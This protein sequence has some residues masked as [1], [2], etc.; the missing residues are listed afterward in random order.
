M[1]DLLNR[2]LAQL[3]AHQQDDQ[4]NQQ[5][6]QVFQPPMAEGVAVVC[7][8]ARQLEAHQR[9]HGRTGIG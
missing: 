3:Q 4:R 8:L 5:P 9:H 6:R 1:E 7:L 2:A